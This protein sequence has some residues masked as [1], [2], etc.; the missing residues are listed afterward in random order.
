MFTGSVHYHQGGSMIAQAGM[1]EG[2]LRVL[3]F[4]LKAAKRI[5]TLLAN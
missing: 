3:C 4:H 1:V 2:E 5:L